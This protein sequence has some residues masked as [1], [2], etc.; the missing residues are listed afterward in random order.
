MDGTPYIAT[1]LNWRMYCHELWERATPKFS[2]AQRAIDEME[3]SSTDIWSTSTDPSDTV[4]PLRGES[5]F[6]ACGSEDLRAS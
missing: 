2:S 4:A 5:D 1:S 3:N 6:G